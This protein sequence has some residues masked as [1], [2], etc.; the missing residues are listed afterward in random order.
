MVPKE[1]A[2]DESEQIL[3]VVQN[4]KYAQHSK[5]IC[6]LLQFTDET[7]LDKKTFTAMIKKYVKQVRM[8]LKENK[9]EREEAFVSEMNEFIKK[10]LKDFKDYDYYHGTV[11]Y[12]AMEDRVNE[13]KAKAEAAGKDASSLTHLQEMIVICEYVDGVKPTFH[14]FKDG[15]YEEQY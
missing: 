11:D 1:D 13:L 5:V 6:S 10:I 3:D 15:M 12:D 8:Y 9:P 7:A 2:E 14:F 4:H